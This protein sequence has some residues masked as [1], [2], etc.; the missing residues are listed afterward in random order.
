MVKLRMRQ[1]VCKLY[2][3]TSVSSHVGFENKVMTLKRWRVSYRAVTRMNLYY[4]VINVGSFCNNL[5][6]KNTMTTHRLY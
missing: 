3:C 5:I 1:Q 4:E 2:V 6:Y